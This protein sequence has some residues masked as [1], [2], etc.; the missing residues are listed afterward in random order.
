MSNEGDG[1]RR[2]QS[3]KVNMV[4]SALRNLLQVAF[5]LITFP[6]VSR[7]LQV[8]RI[9]AIN[10]CS[11]LMSYFLLVAQFGIN[12][13]AVRDGAKVRDDPQTFQAFANE[14]F[15]INLTTTFVSY[16][17][18]GL[19]MILARP[20]YPYSI[21]LAI[22]S[23]NLVF[24]ALGREWIYKVYEDYAYITARSVAFQIISIIL[25]F[26]FV[27][28]ESDFIIYAAIGVFASSG[29]NVMNLVRSRRY[30]GIGVS[31]SKEAIRRLRVMAVFFLGTL[32][33][34]LY[35]NFDITML[36]TWHGDYSVGIY[37]TAVKVYSI[38]VSVM[39]AIVTVA[40]P[41]I[42]NLAVDVGRRDELMEMLRQTHHLAL[43]LVAPLAVGTFMLADDTV[44]VLAGEAYLQASVPLRV[45]CLSL[46]FAILATFWGQCVL[47]PFDK[48]KVI[49][50]NVIACAAIN[51]VLNALLIPSYGYTAAAA[52]TAL[53]QF[54]SMM[55]SFV[56]AR[57]HV[58]E[59]LSGMGIITKVMLGC[60]GVVA[61]CFTCSLIDS[62]VIRV[63]SSVLLSIVAYF[64]I[65]LAVSNESVTSILQSI[66]A[67]LRQ[68][69]SVAR[70]K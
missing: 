1:K 32:S 7:V 3:V 70:T 20:S 61:A 8:D 27:R 47:I 18:L 42:S 9:G 55:I 64:L 60:V 62:L 67:R 39:V 15:G 34:T 56:Y 31:F 51:L 57:R 28:D 59:S 54:A 26:A 53:S 44:L 52:T 6:Y 29:S 4:L 50:G 10:Y 40:M 17:L 13:Y 58:I 21:L 16:F 5:P 69:L 45:L 24:T 41:R 36:G 63:A 30:C 23:L 35:T 68:H 49:L 38:L 22:Q 12:D 2:L 33:V 48:E 19:Y 14:V 46:V 11:A 37:S 65:E 25:M 66:R 43:T